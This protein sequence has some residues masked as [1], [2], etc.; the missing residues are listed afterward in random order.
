MAKKTRY[1]SASGPLPDEAFENDIRP[2]RP[3]SSHMS[4]KD[5]E[6]FNRRTEEVRQAALAILARKKTGE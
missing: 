1:R 5:I 4:P 6:A 3:L 2:T